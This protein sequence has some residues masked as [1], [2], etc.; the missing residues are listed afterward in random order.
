MM[1]D[2]FMPQYNFN[3]VH[4]LVVRASPHRVYE[5][6][7]RVSLVEMP[8]VAALLVFRA[9]PALLTGS[10]PALLN[11]RVPFLDAALHGGFVLLTDIA[12]RELVIASIGQFWVLRGGASATVATPEAFLAFDRPGYV[13]VATNFL[14]EESRGGTRLST[15][16]RVRALDPESRRKFARYWRVIYPGSALIRRMWLRAIK[17]RA[18]RSRSAEN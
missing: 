15:E 8:L 12:D 6:I 10:R 17:R 1:L 5:A 16:T 14:L 9:L 3:E 18:E 2:H 7:H 11:S 4:W 13:K